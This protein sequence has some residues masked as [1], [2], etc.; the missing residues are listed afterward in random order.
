MSAHWTHVARIKWEAVAF[1]DGLLAGITCWFPESHV[2]RKLVTIPY[3]LIEDSNE[4]G[5]GHSREH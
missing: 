4:R 3:G 5:G 1:A 2:E